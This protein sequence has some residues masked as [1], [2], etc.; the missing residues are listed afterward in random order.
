ML[1]KSPISDSDAPS[2]SVWLADGRLIHDDDLAFFARR[3]GADEADRYRRFAR[4]ERQRQFLVGRILLRF[5]IGRLTGLPLAAIGIAE[6]PGNAPRL[7]LPDSHCLQ[8]GFSLSHSGNWI[9]CTVSRDTRLG[10]DIEIINPKRDIA[11]VAESAFPADEY[12]WL[13]RQPDEA[14][15]AAFYQLWSFREA[16][17]KLQSNVGS[18]PALPPLL[19]AKGALAAQGAGWHRYVMPHAAFSCV[20]CSAQPLA[21]LRLAESAELTRSAWLAAH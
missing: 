11:G 2:A 9:A 18:G 7:S 10:I 17:Y 15:T 8:P 6:Q 13:Q 4:R 3:L 21:A 5:A 12:A 16:L 19:D 14:Q 1:S 20:V